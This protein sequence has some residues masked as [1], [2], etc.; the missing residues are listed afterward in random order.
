MKQRKNSNILE[1]LNTRLN[2]IKDILVGKNS[3]SLDKIDDIIDDLSKSVLNKDRMNYIDIIKDK[4][5]QSIT[6]RY[7]NPLK[8]L[9]STLLQDIE[10]RTRLK[11]Y[12]NSEEIIDN[13]PYASSAIQILADETVSPDDITK[14]SIQFLNT[15]IMS[16]EEKKDL[17]LDYI[18]KI[19]E[20]LNIDDLL[21]DI[22]YNTMKYGDQFVEICDIK[23]K[24]APITQALLSEGSSQEYVN[25]LK[26]IQEDPIKFEYLQENTE[27]H[28]SIKKSFNLKLEVYMDKLDTVDVSELSNDG[29]ITKRRKREID[30]KNEEFVN[31]NNV[32]LVMH[33]PAYVIK[34]QSKRFR[35][36]LGY[37]VLPKYESTVGLDPS[38]CSSSASSSALY[39]PMGIGSNIPTILSGVDTLYLKLIKIIKKYTH[40]DDLSINKNETQDILNRVVREIEDAGDSVLRIRFV[41]SEQM[42]HFVTTNLR[43]Y[44][45]GESIL[46]KSF[47]SA[48][49]LILQEVATAMKRMSDSIDRRIWKVE[50]G[51]S[52]QAKNSIDTLKQALKKRKISLDTFGSI[53]TIPSML[54]AYEDLYVPVTKGKAFVD[55]ETMSPTTNSRDAAEELKF[56][57]DSFV[58][59]LRVP[60]SYIGLEENTTNKANLSQQSQIFARVII[61]TQK[62][63]S[64]HLSGLF[65]KIY[66]FTKKK[67]MPKII[68]TLPPPKLLQVEIMAEHVRTS[69]EIIDSLDELDIPKEYSKKKYLNF[70]WDD[71]DRFKAKQKLEDKGKPKEIKPEDQL[72]GTGLGGGGFGGN[73]FGTD[74]GGTS[75]TVPGEPPTP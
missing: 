40:N 42:E 17:D 9:D 35:L 41:S 37:L 43:F 21:S 12:I 58:A 75:T 30:R 22:V 14:Q 60:P 34:I 38:G 29:S 20:S 44:P 71:L 19:N 74:I 39:S 15:N 56:F 48:K 25:D 73:S 66:K 67:P 8:D 7:D 62:T 50:T 1:N 57:R 54:T 10:N 31:I 33:D 59:S 5:T 18:R 13:I 6:G 23:S 2:K 4:I 61:S 28:Q 53:S 70:D 49:L 11:R 36:C 52:R 65:R 47:F 55:T 32:R 24:E 26:K 64:K 16:E 51:L 45:Y 63:F 68:I 72:Y 3:K 69:K 27:N 46:Y